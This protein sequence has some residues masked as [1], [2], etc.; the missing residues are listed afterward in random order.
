MDG[1]GRLY[2]IEVNPNPDLSP[3]AGLARQASAAG[4]SYPE[5]IGRIAELAFTTEGALARERGAR[6]QARRREAV[7]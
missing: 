1:R 5:L 7:R 6:R 4:W 3:D 2:V